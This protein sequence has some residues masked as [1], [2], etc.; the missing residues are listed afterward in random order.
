M[1]R[2]AGARPGSIAPMDADETHASHAAVIK[3]LRRAAGH[4]QNVIEMME[5][6]R[7]CTDVA[8][9]LHAVERAITAAKPQ[10]IHDHI[11]HCLDHALASKSRTTRQVLDEFKSISKYL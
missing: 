4:L 9:Q 8:Q 3:R 7:P 1:S 11:D 6:D 5:V 10:L 2:Q